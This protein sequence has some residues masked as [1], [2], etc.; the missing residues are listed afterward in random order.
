MSSSPPYDTLYK[1]IT[2]KEEIEKI[3]SN[4][5]NKISEN[6][7]FYFLAMPDKN[8]L[9]AS[10]N[11]LAK[12]LTTD[13]K[14]PKKL[15]KEVLQKYINEFKNADEIVKT[16]LD[17]SI[18]LQDLN[19]SNIEDKTTKILEIPYTLLT[20]AEIIDEIEIY[21]T[22]YAAARWDIKSCHDDIAQLK[23][24]MNNVLINIKPPTKIDIDTS[25]DPKTFLLED[26]TKIEKKSNKFED[27]KKTVINKFNVIKELIENVTTIHKEVQ[28]NST[29]FNTALQKKV[30]EAYKTFNDTWN[31]SDLIGTGISGINSGFKDKFLDYIEDEKKII[32]RN[33][34]DFDKI[35]INDLTLMMKYT[36]I[37]GSIINP[38]R[39]DKFD[40]NFYNDYDTDIFKKIK[41]YYDEIKNNSVL[42]KGLSYKTK[43]QL[44][45]LQ[46]NYD[47][48][49]LTIQFKFLELNARIILFYHIMTLYEK[50][51]HPAN[52][53]V[54]KQNIANLLIFLIYTIIKLLGELENH[55]FI[56]SKSEIAIF[57]NKTNLLTLNSKNLL[58]EK[59][60]VRETQTMINKIYT[61]KSDHFVGTNWFSPK[62]WYDIAKMKEVYLTDTSE[63]WQVIEYF[64]V[65]LTNYPTYNSTEFNKLKWPLNRLIPM[66]QELTIEIQNDSTTNVITYPSDFFSKFSLYDGPTLPFMKSKGGGF[67]LFNKLNKKT[68]KKNQLIK[69]KTHKN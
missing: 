39:E 4:T 67:N 7:T 3:D 32:D 49:G 45:D 11:I 27:F 62:K 20:E 66:I 69:K 59:I 48:F 15:L 26:K 14:N 29:K 60:L 56:F 51:K 10:E 25:I 33:I 64:F 24:D 5:I 53:G 63:P 17:S 38:P 2:I 54:L 16:L 50:K 31:S 55:C 8:K 22:E 18:I 12:D 34:Q 42:D 61:N 43:E 40:N 47:L 44:E 23:I 9:V 30:D 35:T 57:F 28:N 68:F 52:A 36:E 13:S 65:K 41:E 46:K 21:K 19:S 1:H 37:Q 58:D 6:D